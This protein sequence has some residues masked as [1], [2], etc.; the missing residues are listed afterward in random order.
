MELVVHRAQPRFEHMRIDLGGRQIG[1]AEHH[2][3]HAQIG[4]AIP[5][6]NRGRHA[7]PGPMR[8][9]SGVDPTAAV[10]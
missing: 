1:V 6:V 5:Q 2:L 8:A 3:D 7:G 10:V 9:P 4:A